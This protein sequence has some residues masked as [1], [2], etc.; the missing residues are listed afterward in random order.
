MAS[1]RKRNNLWQAQVRNKHIG[2]ITKS[3]HIKSEAQKWAKE[4]EVLMQS[5]QWSR[6]NEQSF[7][8]HALISK[9]KNEITPKKRG[10]ITEDQRLRRLLREKDLMS[11]PLERLHPPT[12]AAFRDRRLKDGVRACQ[13]DLVLIRHA[14]NIA[15]IEWGW[16]LGENPAQKIRMPKNN[17]PR[18]RRLKSGEYDRLKNASLG[19]KVW[20]LW[21]IIDFAIETGMRRGEILGMK[22]ENIGVDNQRVLLPLT[23]N[24]SSRWV[25]LS[26]RAMEILDQA[27]RTTER[28]FPITDVA[29]RQ[30]WERLRN[31]ANLINFT[32]HDLRHEAISRMFEKGLNVPEVASISGHKTASQLFRYVQVKAKL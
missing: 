10:H 26:K 16:N 6:F 9:Y 21:P 20:Y 22:W 11:M 27:P 15:C 13:Y 18:E 19:T 23:K 8:L 32:F 24:G 25:P 31:R 5:G 3:F 14:W 4:Q 2:S 12:L 29:L 30:S 1:F 7:T 28:V 17:P